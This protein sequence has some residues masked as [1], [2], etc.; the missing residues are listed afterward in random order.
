MADVV[1]VSTEGR[2]YCFLLWLLF[3]HTQR[4]TTR[5]FEILD[6]EPAQPTFSTARVTC[7]AFSNTLELSRARLVSW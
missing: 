5:H 4:E 7:A 1:V 6:G 2:M 3:L